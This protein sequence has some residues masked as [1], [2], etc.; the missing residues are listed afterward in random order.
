MPFGLLNV[1]GEICPVSVGEHTIS[2]HEQYKRLLKL[3][4]GHELEPEFAGALLILAL[5]QV[6]IPCH[7]G[8]WFHSKLLDSL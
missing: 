8:Y 7:Q 3:A 1:G 5:L 6:M 4:P 2:V